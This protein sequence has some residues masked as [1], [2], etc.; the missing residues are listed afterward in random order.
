MRPSARDQEDRFRLSGRLKERLDNSAAK[1][2][3]AVT[4]DDA[5][6]TAWVRAQGSTRFSKS[7]SLMVPI[8]LLPIVVTDAKEAV[9]DGNLRQLKR[10]RVLTSGGIYGT[11][12][13]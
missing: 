10:R 1:P 8:R 13:G 6:F 9:A 4:H 7:A 11:V 2:S 3:R 12:V 5:M